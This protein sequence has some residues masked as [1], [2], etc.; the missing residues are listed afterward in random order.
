MFGSRDKESAFP[1][2]DDDN[3]HAN[4]QQ[5]M[6]NIAILSSLPILLQQIVADSKDLVLTGGQKL[7]NFILPDW[8]YYSSKTSETM[9]TMKQLLQIARNATTTTPMMEYMLR[10]FDTN[11]DGHI[12]GAEL[13]TMAEMWKQQMLNAERGMSWA[14]WFQREW[15]LMDWKIGM[16]LWSTFGGILFLLAGFSIIPG[17]M[18]RISAKILRWP[19]LGVVYFLI[20]VELMCV[21]WSY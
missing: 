12:S 20:A 15:P 6:T 21:K 11:G 3:N 9:P 2:D 8:D 18:H 16:F 13:L 1:D 5:N 17:Q 4:V 10:H 14:T 7:W 19:V